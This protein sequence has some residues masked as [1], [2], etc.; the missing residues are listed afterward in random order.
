[1]FDLLILN[2]SYVSLRLFIAS[3][4]IYFLKKYINYYLAVLIFSQISFLYDAIFFYNYFDVP[5]LDIFNVLYTDIIR[6][7]RVLAAWSLIA[8]LHKYFNWNISVIISSEITFTFDY[9]IFKYF[10]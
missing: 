9:Y 5:D 10:V 3:P 2:L 4:F 6:T 1:M 8:W 7:I